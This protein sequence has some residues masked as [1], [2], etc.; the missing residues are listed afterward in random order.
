MSAPRQSALPVALALLAPLALSGCTEDV[1]APN[2]TS[3]AEASVAAGP[4]GDA[5][6][7]TDLNDITLGAKIE[8]PQG[9]EPSGPLV[10]PDG[11]ELGTISSYVAC[12]EGMDVCLPEEAPDGTIYTYVHTIDPTARA[13]RFRSASPVYGFNGTAGFDKLQAGATLGGDVLVE[14]RCDKGALV[15]SVS[16]GAGWQEPVR[17]FWQST[18]PP[19]G[20]AP[21]GYVMVAETGGRALGPGP[22]PA[23]PETDA[24]ADEGTAQGKRPETKSSTNAPV[25]CS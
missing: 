12:P 14:M 1:D 17:F 19:A 8:G 11:K 23:A 5:M 9:P 3:V 6:E 2:R 4:S 15:W 16:G 20:P 25:G 18:L 21:K 22:A 13:V 24:D 7:T 10:G